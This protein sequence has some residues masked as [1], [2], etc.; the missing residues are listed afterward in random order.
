LGEKDLDSQLSLAG[1]KPPA[2]LG[3]GKVTLTSVRVAD[4]RT[5]TGWLYRCGVKLDAGDNGN[6]TW[7]RDIRRS[8]NGIRR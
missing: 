1:C 7:N 3:T 5:R 8:W 4:R 2:R 6:L